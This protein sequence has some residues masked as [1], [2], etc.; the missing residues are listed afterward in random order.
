MALTLAVL[1]SVGACGG[2]GA[3]PG[4]PLASTAEPDLSGVQGDRTVSVQSDVGLRPVLIHH[5]DSVGAHAPLVMV[6]HGEGTGAA[7]TR[8]KLGW[9][10]VADHEGFVVAYPEAVNHVWNAGPT[11]CFPNNSGINDVGYLNE[12]LSAMTKQDLIDR[13]R[14]YVVGFSSGGSMAYTWACAHPGLL[15]GIGPVEA[16]LLIKCPLEASVS[17]AAVY[18]DAD[19]TVSPAHLE[20]PIPPASE[21]RTN[22]PTTTP[23]EPGGGATS[24]DAADESL[25]LFRRIDECPDQPAISIGGPPASER[26]WNCVATHSVSVT[27]VAGADHQWPRAPRSA[28]RATVTTSSTAAPDVPESDSPPTPDFDTDEWLWTHLRNGRSR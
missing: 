25:A 10:S 28:S 22:L 26:S 20:A 14:V 15:A 27:V 8:D 16:S 24:G 12:A 3:E 1:A 18:G 23:S 2:K 11:C 4:G 5:P 7:Q 21:S 19:R 9:N 13:S 6:L 17:L